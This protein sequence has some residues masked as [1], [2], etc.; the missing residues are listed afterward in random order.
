M[1]LNIKKCHVY[2]INEKNKYFYSEFSCQKRKFWWKEWA[3]IYVTYTFRVNLHWIIALMTRNSG[4]ELL[5][6]S[7][8]DIWNL[9]VNNRVRT[10]HHLFRKLTTQPVWLNGWVFVS[11]LIGCGLEFSCSLN[12][13]KVI[14]IFIK[15]ICTEYFICKGCGQL[16]IAR[17]VME[18]TVLQLL[19]LISGEPNNNK[20]R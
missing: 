2:F 4:Q 7:W 9:S 16:N 18:V 14:R 10:L 12:L 13:R 8:F 6:R 1:Y 19:M 20:D 5:S 17:E 15:L 3:T 11:K